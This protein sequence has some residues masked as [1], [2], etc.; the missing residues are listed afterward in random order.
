MAS[1]I[2]LGSGCRF[3]M[4]PCALVTPSDRP[5]AIVRAADSPRASGG[6]RSVGMRS[7]LRDA[8]RIIGYAMHSRRR[9]VERSG[10][11]NLPGGDLVLRLLRWSGAERRELGQGSATGECRERSDHRRGCGEPRR[12]GRTG[13]LHVPR[14]CRRLLRRSRG[15]HGRDAQPNVQMLVR[16]GT[17]L[18][19]RPQA[20][21]GR[22]SNAQPLE[23]PY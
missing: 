4:R 22:A 8:D 19:P 14:K 5:I 1:G 2:C 6:V 21:R 23:F 16:F 17:C 20:P 3:G 7:W 12:S 10:D 11:R 18:F 13:L 15:L 9:S